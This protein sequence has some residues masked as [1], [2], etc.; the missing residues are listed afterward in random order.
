M[1]NGKIKKMK[2]NRKKSFEEEFRFCWVHLAF[3]LSV[4]Q[5][6]L[7]FGKKTNLSASKERNLYLYQ[8]TRS[9]LIN[10]I[11]LTVGLLEIRT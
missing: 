6:N 4:S 7:M 3:K 1:R 11:M 2:K 10:P 5:V 8:C 9:A